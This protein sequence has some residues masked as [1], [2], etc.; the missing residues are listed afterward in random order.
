VSKLIDSFCRAYLSYFCFH[1]LQVMFYEALKDLTEYAKQKW[2]PSLDHH[3][4]S[5]VEGLLLGGLA[6]GTC[7]TSALSE[8][9]L[10]RQSQQ[11]FFQWGHYYFNN[12]FFYLFCHYIKLAS[13]KTS[14]YDT[15]KRFNTIITS[16]TK[17]S[18][19]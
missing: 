19:L 17:I 12:H 3:I 10:A 7:F 18:C 16:I 13:H 4:N 8:A 9:V 1:Y 15:S 2:I 11:S 6:G 14:S 5:S